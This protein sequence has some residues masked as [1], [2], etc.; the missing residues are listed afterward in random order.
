MTTRWSTNIT[1]A[2][3]A[4]RILIGGLGAVA[5]IVLLA[6]ATS[7]LAVVL[8]LL[9]VVAGLDLVVTGAL[10]HCPLYAKLGH[11]PASLKGSAS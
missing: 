4:A 3:R 9:L 8:E 7:T 11:V 6:G 10:G 5:G 1:P 2:E